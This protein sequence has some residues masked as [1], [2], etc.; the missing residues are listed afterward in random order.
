MLLKNTG[1]FDNASIASLV[2][3]IV[4]MKDFQHLN[5]LTLMGVALD[6]RNSPC[7]VMPYMSNGS[8]VEY[9]RRE[10]VREELLMKADAEEEFVVS[11][12]QY[13]CG[14]CTWRNLQ[15]AWTCLGQED[16]ACL[17]SEINDELRHQQV[18]LILFLICSR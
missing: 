3:E 10:S 6:N 11:P 2:D 12:V 14:C 17:Y 18:S 5:V 8:L 13:E 15:N 4:R 7:L 16:F 1:F 9:L